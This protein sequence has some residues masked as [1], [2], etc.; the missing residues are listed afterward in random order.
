MKFNEQNTKNA[1]CNE[2]SDDQLDDVSGGMFRPLLRS[3]VKAVI[4]GAK[5]IEENAGKGTLPDRF[6]N[7]IT[8]VGGG[9]TG[10]WN[11]PGQEGSPDPTSI[12]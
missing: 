8:D 2:L 9:G 11:P 6:M 1:E 4:E 10:V 12:N 3:F 7:P 5:E